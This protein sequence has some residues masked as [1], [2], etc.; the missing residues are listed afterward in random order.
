MKMVKDGGGSSGGLDERS[1]LRY[2]SPG[3]RIGSSGILD[4]S[5]FIQ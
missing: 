3:S 1:K 5:E 4:H 2:Q